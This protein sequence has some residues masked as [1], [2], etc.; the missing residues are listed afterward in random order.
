MNRFERRTRGIGF[1][2]LALAGVAT[3]T[4]GARSSA[5]HA[6]PDAGPDRVIPAEGRDPLQPP[7]RLAAA[8]DDA[9]AT[10]GRRCIVPGYEATGR[11]FSDLR[12]DRN[13]VIVPD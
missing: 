9:C 12:A 7:V 4:A 3:P 13:R 6:A 8:A 5:F 1:H 10:D 11:E 2:R